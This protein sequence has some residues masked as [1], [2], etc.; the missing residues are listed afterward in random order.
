MHGFGGIAVLKL[1][2]E[3]PGYPVLVF[4]FFPIRNITGYL[5]LRIV[6]LS[7]L[8]FLLCVELIRPVPTL[9][10]IMTLRCLNPDG[11]KCKALSDVIKGR[12][13]I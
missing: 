9:H 3:E 11:I 8:L 1:K 6:R 5:F 2:K 7:V 4:P 10:G 12:D 13:L